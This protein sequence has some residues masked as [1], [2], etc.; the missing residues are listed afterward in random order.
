[1]EPRLGRVTRILLLFAAIYAAAFPIVGLVVPAYSST[2][3]SVS[4][5]GTTTH[6]SSGGTL[7]AV[8]GWR[9]LIVL[10]LPLVAVGL[11]WCSLRWRRR[12]DHLDAG[13]L[14]WT[15]VGLLGVMSVLGILSI[16]VFILP[17][18]G[19]LAGACATAAGAP[20]GTPGVDAGSFP[21]G[22]GRLG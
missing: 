9:V 16:G 6:S 17:L 5:N 21:R 18:V 20:S 13:A 3:T 22:P 12:R 15:V 4:S 19:L 2:T 14:A 1:M 11:V 10:A 8:N 7:V